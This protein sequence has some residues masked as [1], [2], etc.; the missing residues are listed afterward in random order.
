MPLKLCN[1]QSTVLRNVLSIFLSFRR[2]WLRRKLLMQWTISL[3]VRTL[4][5]RVRRYLHMSVRYQ[6]VTNFLV[7]QCIFLKWRWSYLPS[8]YLA[9]W[10]RHSASWPSGELDRVPGEKD[11]FRERSVSTLLEFSSC[12]AKAKMADDWGDLQYIW[13]QRDNFGN[14]LQDYI[15]H[16]EQSSRSQN[17]VA[18]KA[19]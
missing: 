11:M 8:C 18:H 6:T 7:T 10:L 1:L 16:I 3:G 5:C 12:F 14:N 17:S 13:R 15:I 2:Y 9:D 4:A 19:G